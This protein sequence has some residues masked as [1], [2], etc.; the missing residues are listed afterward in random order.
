MPWKKPPKVAYAVFVGRTPGVYSTWYDSLAYLLVM[1]TD[2]KLGLKR[3]K[4]SK[5]SHVPITGATPLKREDVPRQKR[6]FGNMAERR[7]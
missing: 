2:P 3:R 6:T 7:R 5:A 4:K 1:D